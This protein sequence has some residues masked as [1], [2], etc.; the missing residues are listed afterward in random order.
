MNSSIITSTYLSAPISP[1]IVS[2]SPKEIKVGNNYE[3]CPAYNNNACV[4]DVGL[5]VL[6]LLIDLILRAT[7]GEKHYY[8]AFHK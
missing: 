4:P 8:P 6:H 5:S 2:A 7:L 1:L 3:K